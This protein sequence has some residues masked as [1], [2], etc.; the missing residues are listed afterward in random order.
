MVAD[1]IKKL[2]EKKGLTQSDLAKYLGITRSSVNAWEQGISIPST[3]YILQLATFFKVSTD[4]LLCAN[5]T[6]N[7][8]ADGLTAED[9]EIV[10]DFVSYL[11][12]KNLS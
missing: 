2:R 8:P 11:R 9:I 10:Q 12:R 5:N 4:Y 3:Q 7:I 6:I 1:R